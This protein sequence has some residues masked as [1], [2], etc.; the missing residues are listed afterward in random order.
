MAIT[1]P[2]TASYNRLRA[3]PQTDRLF[4]LDNL[5]V[6]ATCVVIAHH[7]GQAYGPTGGA[8][9][10]SEAARAAVLGPFFTVNRSFGMSL[11]FLIAGY[12]MVRSYDAHG[13][14]PFV[15]GRLTRLGIPM[16]IF[17]ILTVPIM[18]LM[19]VTPPENGGFFGL[20]EPNALH[21]WFVQHLLI[22][23]LCYAGI[24]VYLDRRSAQQRSA[25]EQAPI[26]GSTI[27]VLFALALAV[28][29]ATVRIWFPIDYWLN[30]AFIRVAFADVPRDLSF[31][32]IGALAYRHDW[33]RRFPRRAGYAWLAVGLLLGV[34][35]YVYAL[36]SPQL[37]SIPTG[38]AGLPYAIWESLLCCGMCLGLIVLFRDIANMRTPLLTEL[39]RGQYLAYVIHVAPVI[40]LQAIAVAL[41]ISP[42]AKFALV[43]VAAIPLSFMLAGL[44]RRPLKM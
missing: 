42:L 30:P 9:P 39:G 22:Y 5:R 26:P 33:L 14:R 21:L 13:P 11:F 4:F 3:E 34:F 24:R 32:V 8:W 27:I 28:V 29:S 38:A 43:T 35:W 16:L 18:L 25:F 12:L 44:L 15:I 19:G 36:S 17:T 6:F 7:V 10:V 23:S 41:P 37:V 20:P 2:F 40:G 1:N 31:F